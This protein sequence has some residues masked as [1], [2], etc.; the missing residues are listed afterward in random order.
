[1]SEQLAKG[2]SHTKIGDTP[3]EA[4]SISIESKRKQVINKEVCKRQLHFI[5]PPRTLVPTK[6]QNLLSLPAIDLGG[7]DRFA[8]LNLRGFKKLSFE[9]IVLHIAGSRRLLPWR[10]TCEVALLT[11]EEMIEQIIKTDC[12]LH[13]ILK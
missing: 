6:L 2:I 12:G 9:P 3:A 7:Q 5:L 13:P 4:S 10:L 11:K 8:N 1:M